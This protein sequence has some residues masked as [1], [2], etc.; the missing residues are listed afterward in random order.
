MQ[1]LVVILLSVALALASAHPP[2]SNTNLNKRTSGLKS[3]NLGGDSHGD[4]DSSGS[5]KN[6]ARRW[7]GVAQREATSDVEQGS[8]DEKRSSITIPLVR[9]GS[10]HHRPIR[11]GLY[12]AK[13]LEANTAVTDVDGL[14]AARDALIDK[15]VEGESAK[16]RLRERRKKRDAE[17]IE[18][19]MRKRSSKEKRVVNDIAM[20]NHNF[21]TVYSANLLLGTPAKSFSVLLD[22]GSSY[23]FLLVFIYSLLTSCPI[24]TP[25]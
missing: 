11:A 21:D 22:T 17:Q 4:T 2:S 7:E 19:E 3:H 23:V 20:T 12:S 9:R 24:A 8:T 15:Y 16:R 5:V 13:E 25:G 6:K 1:R 10:A 18:E 14:Q